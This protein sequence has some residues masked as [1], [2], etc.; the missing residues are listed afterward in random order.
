MPDFDVIASE[1]SQLS[2]ADR[3][4]LI[5]Q[6][7]ASVPDHQPPSLS[8]QF[9]VN[10]AGDKWSA[11]LVALKRIVRPKLRLYSKKLC[12]SFPTGNRRLTKFGGA[13]NFRPLD[14]VRLHCL[15]S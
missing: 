12:P 4:R 8:G 13:N 15:K 5:D 2:V 6:L 14:L 9:F 3:L 7:A 10:P 11:T 1:A